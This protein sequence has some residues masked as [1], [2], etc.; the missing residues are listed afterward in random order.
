MRLARI[1][2]ELHTQ[3][4]GCT[5]AKLQDE[6]GVSERTLLR[7]VSTLRDLVDRDGNPLIV[8]HRNGDRRVLRLA[9]DAHGAEL[10][11]YQ[12]LSFYFALSVFQFLDGTVLKSGVQDLWERFHRAVPPGQ[13]ARLADLERKF[14]AIPHA[15]KDYRDHDQ[16]LDVIVRA[17]VNC[18]TLGI[19][20]APVWG[21][22]HHHELDPYTLAMYRGG[23]YVIGRTHA[24]KRVVWLAVERMQRVE[25]R[26]EHFAY[27]RRYSPEKHTEGMFGIVE[28]A[29]TAVELLVH[30]E[31]TARL[32]M[33]RRL[34]PTQQFETR[35]DGKS[36]LRM[37]VRGTG[38]LKFWVLSHGPYVEV[39][40]PASLRAELRQALREA[41]EMY[42]HVMPVDGRTRP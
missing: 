1:V 25:L 16:T 17:L 27:P 14:Y 15:M 42:D 18:W 30:N 7:Y 6:L 24:R 21:E 41:C 3:P 39:L 4:F 19:D 13:Q 36:I 34:H 9:E 29:E 8:V 10:T 38:E 23:L 20:Y 40:K 28:G 35:P 5:F 11:A 26:R 32:L 33:S 2:H 37:T 22:E 12:A 31:D